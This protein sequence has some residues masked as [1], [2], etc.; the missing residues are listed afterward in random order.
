M[1]VSA[2]WIFVFHTWY[3]MFTPETSPKLLY[4]IELAITKLG[5]FGVDIFFLLSGIGL[6]YAIAK[7]STKEFYRRRFRR[8]AFP[9]L[10]AAAVLAVMRGWSFPRYLFV[11]SGIGFF[12]GRK[13]FLWFISAIT[14]TYLLFPL[15][16]HFFY[17][18]RSKC[19]FT[20]LFIAA[21][22]LCSV[23]LDGV[24]PSAVFLFITRVP[25]FV[26]GILFGWAQRSG[27]LKLS[28]RALNTAALISAAVGTALG[29]L[30]TIHSIDFFRFQPNGFIPGILVAFGYT[31]LL[32]EL[33]GLFDRAG[34]AGRGINKFFGFYGMLSLEL[35]CLQEYLAPIV[36]HAA[37]NAD[38]VGLPVNLIELAAVTF[39]AWLLHIISDGALHLTGRL[40]S[41]A[42]NAG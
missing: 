24:I 29:W 11:A 36:V 23:L 3:R 14:A 38:I 16:W 4:Y 17:R 8:L 18:S 2:L 35:Y 6:S 42:K 25:P 37:W 27:G 15:Y 28:R 40:R 32:A 1:G 39:S 31:V 12:I 9:V 22:Y 21:W 41:R 26:L 33:F 19:R 20:A 34:V 30:A 7:Y 13:F 5:Y 10:I